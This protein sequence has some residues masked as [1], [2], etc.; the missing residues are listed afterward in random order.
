MFACFQQACAAA[1]LEAAGRSKFYDT[2][3]AIFLPHNSVS[4]PSSNLCF[5]CQ[6]NN[7]AI[8]KAVCLSD[9]EKSA[10]VQVAQTHL[11]RA[12]TEREN[13]NVQKLIK[14]AKQQFNDSVK[15]Q[16]RPIQMH[17]SFDFAQQAHYPYD[18]Q[19][20]G[21]EYFKENVAFLMSA[22]WGKQPSLLSD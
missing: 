13:H 1:G 20:T 17:Y 10:Q 19:Q 4:T 14:E 8:Q 5:V 11:D 15:F 2:Y 18:A 21:P 16:S 3:M 12:K 7:L 22:M 9:D 6:Q